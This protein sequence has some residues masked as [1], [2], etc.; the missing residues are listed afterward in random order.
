MSVA[1]QAPQ[2]LNITVIGAKDN[3]DKAVLSF[4]ALVD[5]VNGINKVGQ[6]GHRI[7]ASVIAS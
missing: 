6:N 4:N 2:Q 1:A 7:N 5:I 3:P